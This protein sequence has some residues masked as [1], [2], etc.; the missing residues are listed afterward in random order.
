MKKLLLAILCCSL[1]TTSNGQAPT[2]DWAFATGGLNGALYN[3][4]MALDNLGNIYSIGHFYSGPVDFDPSSDILNFSSVGGLDIY[5]SKYGTSGQLIWAKRLGGT[6][7]DEGTAIAVDSSG[8]V[9]FT[10]NFEGTADFNP[11]SEVYNLTSNGVKDIFVCK[12]DPEGNF[13]WAKQMGGTTNDK[14][15]GIIVDN[16]GDVYVTGEFEKTVDFDSGTGNSVLT[17]KGQTDM[18]ILKLS[19]TGD[20]KWVKHIGSTQYD[21]GEALAIDSDSN[22]FLT[23]SYTGTVDFDPGDGVAELNSAGASGFVLKLD[24][25]GDFGWVTELPNSLAGRAVTTDATG[26]I[27]VGG[28]GSGIG[29]VKLSPSGIITWE[30]FSPG[31]NSNVSCIAVDDLG[32]VYTTG[33]FRGE[34]DFDPGEDQVIFDSGSWHDGYINKFDASGNYIWA[35]QWGGPTA[36][37]Y[38]I[39]MALDPAGNIYASGHFRSEIDFDPG[40]NTFN[41]KSEYSYYRYLLKWNQET[42]GLEDQ[43]QDIAM[44]LHPN[45]T[46][47]QIN[48]EFS[49]LQDRIELRLFSITG[50]LVMEKQFKNTKNISLELH[51]S[52]GL[53]IAEF[54]NGKGQKSI[55]KIMKQ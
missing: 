43:L 55:L 36:R 9:Y 39:A 24:A 52:T 37:N 8:N 51:Q 25:A 48:I 50:Q 27:Y 16:S 46:N 13:L 1:W 26:N 4:S 47:G 53:Y 29:V 38:G 5:V 3:N 17:S 28:G 2:F 23:G 11:G 12:L 30:K 34:I 19:T 6:E 42:A 31:P 21:R 35:Y 40:P 41:L 10:G 54:K 7:D 18:F 14:G 45:P 33:S 22:L 32:Q 20:F 49:R 15:S 44:S